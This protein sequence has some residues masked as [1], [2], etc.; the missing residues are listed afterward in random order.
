MTSVSSV[1][2]RWNGSGGS[3]SFTYA[4]FAAD[5][6]ADLDR[7]PADP[8]VAAAHA[9]A[10]AGVRLE[11]EAR[12]A[13]QVERLERVRHHAEPQ[14]AVQEAHLD[15][16]GAGRAVLAEGREDVVGE[17]AE[18]L[19]DGARRGPVRPWRVLPSS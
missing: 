16:G 15:A 6:L 5:V 10:R 14:L 18:A 9:G 12:V 11:G 19:F 17:G 7:P 4:A 13:A 2:K 1:R 3:T 8:D